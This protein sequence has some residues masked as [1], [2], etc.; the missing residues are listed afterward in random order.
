MKLSELFFSF[1]KIGLMTF[2]GGYSMLPILEK[3][4]V[5][6]HHWV[7][8]D[9]MLNYY[10]I[11]QCTPGVIAVNTATFIGSKE[12][13]IIGGIV[14]SLGV[15]FPSFVIISLLSSLIA[16][17]KDNLYVLKAFNGIRLAVCA[18]ITSSV[19]RLA[20]K[21]VNDIICLL[22]ALNSIVL[23]LFLRVNSIFIIILSLIFGSIY[24]WFLRKA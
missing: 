9:E 18:L 10:A 21:S 2:G 20:K 15:V 13:G 3:E 5:D 8:E 24:F 23:A 16:I 6:K 12:K 7:T 4:C 22:L 11:G 17:F 14:A 19:I 1:C